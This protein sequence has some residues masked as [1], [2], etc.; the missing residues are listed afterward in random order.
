MSI[1]VWRLAFV[2]SNVDAC[3]LGCASHLLA[4][5]GS[6]EL[7]IV[8]KSSLVVIHGWVTATADSGHDAMC[9]GMD[10]TFHME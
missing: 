1:A 3:A 2:S 6:L 4:P 9:N 8:K 10:R 7:T 5:Q